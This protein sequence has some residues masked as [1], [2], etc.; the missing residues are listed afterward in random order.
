MGLLETGVDAS[1]TYARFSGIGVLE[2][3]TLSLD[4]LGVFSTSDNCGLCGSGVLARVLDGVVTGV[5]EEPPEDSG[6]TI[7]PFGFM[8]DTM[9]RLIGAHAVSSGGNIEW[10]AALPTGR[11]ILLL[12]EGVR[13]CGSDRLL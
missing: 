3:A 13:V 12:V 4:A 9:P 2:R 6:E 5:R 7:P 10:N 1:S 11:G 8:R